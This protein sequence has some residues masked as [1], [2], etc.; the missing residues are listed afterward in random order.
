[1]TKSEK[2]QHQM[3][4]IE[5]DA[6]EE[7]CKVKDYDIMD[8]GEY[9]STSSNPEECYACATQRYACEHDKIDWEEYQCGNDDYPEWW[10][11]V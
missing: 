2:S 7:H 5:Q 8:N 3:N 10:E 1:M 11:E 6:F 4:E 9:I